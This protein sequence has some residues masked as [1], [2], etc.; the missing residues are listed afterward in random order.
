MYLTVLLP[1]VRENESTLRHPELIVHLV[2]R[3][4]MREVCRGGSKK[5]KPEKHGQ[6]IL[7]GAV[8]RQRAASFHAA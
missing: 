7:I 6:Y 4:H 8:G 2:D 1:C 5:G 3:S